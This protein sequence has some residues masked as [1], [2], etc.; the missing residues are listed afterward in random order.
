MVFVYQLKSCIYKD[1]SCTSHFGWLSD[2]LFFGKGIL[3]EQ[4]KTL[5]FNVYFL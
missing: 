3:L 1:T 2:I 5:I 4:L